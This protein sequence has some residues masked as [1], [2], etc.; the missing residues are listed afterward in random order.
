MRENHIQKGRQAVVVNSKLMS[1]LKCL[2]FSYIITGVMLLILALMLFRFDL[3]ESIVSI[4]IIGIYIGSTFF[5]GFMVGKNIENKK[6]LWGLLEGLLYFAILLIVSLL[7]NHTLK[8]I[9]TN[10]STAFVIC[11]GSGMLGGMLS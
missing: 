3:K 1:V 4:A 7:V 5:A 8:D 11:G 10:L 2:L 9:T 6:F